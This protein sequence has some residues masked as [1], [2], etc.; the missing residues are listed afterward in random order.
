MNGLD[1]TPFIVSPIQQ[2]H[3]VRITSEELLDVQVEVVWCCCN[4]EYLSLRKLSL[5]SVQ[6]PG[7]DD[8]FGIQHF[9][10]SKRNG[11][12]LCSEF[13]QCV[14]DEGDQLAT[15]DECVQ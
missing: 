11:P 10:N 13:V 1:D 7:G 3:D 15:L 4:A 2:C 14:K 5:E 12:V 6:G 9:K 8:R